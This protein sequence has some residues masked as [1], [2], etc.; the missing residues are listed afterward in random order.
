MK[1]RFEKEEKMFELLGFTNVAS[2]FWNIL[3]YLGMIVIIVGV[4]FKTEKWQSHFFVWGPLALM[5]Y[6][7]FFLHNPLLTGLQLIIAVSGILNLL[8]IKK[9]ALLVVCCLTMIIYIL[10]SV[11]GSISGIWYWIG[12]FGLLWI[13]LGLTQLP[14][15]K[16]FVM[17]A[18]GGALIIL[19][20]GALGIWIWFVLNV[21]FFAANLI[22]VIRWKS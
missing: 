3:A 15:K 14:K 6:A 1:I 10:L 8:K 16:S 2:I 19:Y 17:M 9:C 5:L 22:K 13:G 18:I 7:W 20:G 21:I 12:S 11:T 4:V